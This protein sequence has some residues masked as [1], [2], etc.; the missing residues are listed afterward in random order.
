MS[1]WSRSEEIGAHRLGPG[2]AGLM[3]RRG[4]L[5]HAGLHALE[6]EL[7]AQAC[8][9]HLVARFKCLIIAYEL[10]EIG[11]ISLRNHQIH[12]AAAL[13]AALADQ[14]A[15]LRSDGHDREAPDVG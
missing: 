4:S 8:A 7:I 13:L 3:H 2:H 6:Q 1:I 5:S 10:R 14:A 11:G 12:E 15:V 9:K